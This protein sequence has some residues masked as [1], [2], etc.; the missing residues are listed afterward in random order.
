[1]P[2]PPINIYSVVIFCLVGA[3]ETTAPPGGVRGYGKMPYPPIRVQNYTNLCDF[4]K[5]RN[6]LRTFFVILFPHPNNFIV[7]D[8]VLTLSLDADDDH[9]VA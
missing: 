1:M 8:T 2:Y 4:H 7:N 9:G 3:V 6:V 5:K